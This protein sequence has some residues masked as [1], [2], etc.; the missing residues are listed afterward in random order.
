MRT[1]QQ[2]TPAE[3]LDAGDGQAPLR[4][5]T[6]RALL[7][8]AGL[9]AAPVALTKLS[10]AGT[11]GAGSGTRT[12][13]TVFLRGAMDGLSLCAPVADSTYQATRGPNERIPLPSFNNGVKWLEPGTWALSAGGGGF[14]D[15]Y[16]DSNL[17][18]V[19]GCGVPHGVR[20]HFDAQFA[21]E[22]MNPDAL[23][24]P[25]DDGA[26][27][28][29]LKSIAGSSNLRAC[30]ISELMPRMLLDAPKGLAIPDPTDYDLPG[31]PLTLNLRKQALHEEYSNTS[32]PLRSIGVDSLGVIDLL[33]GVNFD[34]ATLPSYPSSSFGQKMHSLAQLILDGF[35]L[36]A[37]Q[38]DYG[39]WDDHTAAGPLDGKLHLRLQDL[40]QSINAF[41][42]ELKS[43]NAG[44][45]YT[46]LIVSEFGRR[47]AF[48]GNG[49]MDHGSGNT[50][51]VMGEG[52]NGNQVFTENWTGLANHI[53]LQG[54]L[55]MDFDARDVWAE[56]MVKH[57]GL[58][59]GDVPTVFPGYTYNPRNVVS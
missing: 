1:K 15:A 3:A 24:L 48:N 11:R 27:A 7:T 44:D 43:K 37:A 8:A 45:R 4:R 31:D 36:Q 41:Y 13:V 22:T 18:F 17:A 12:L 52:V 51:I 25:Q 26:V 28:R 10:L 29:L 16:N 39:G 5:N 2:H 47:V 46:L 33:A 34:S 50:M 40:S 20:S 55:L 21:Y 30:S 57:L 53:D 6:R 56:V 38:V 49:G 35:G 59:V 23:A 14:F 19:Q 54:D 9:V 58:A 32:E 42:Q